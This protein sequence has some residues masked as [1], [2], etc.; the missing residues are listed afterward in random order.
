[1]EMFAIVKDLKGGDQQDA[2]RFGLCH[3]HPQGFR[4]PLWTKKTTQ[5]C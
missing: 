4:L 1:M 2:P 3:I 5:S